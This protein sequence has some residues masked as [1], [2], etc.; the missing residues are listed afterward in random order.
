E[1]LLQLGEW[2]QLNGEGIYESKPW[3]KCQKDNVA[4]NIWYT[5][6]DAHTVYGFV[7]QWPEAGLVEF[8]CI[9]LA[10]VASVQ[11]LGSHSV[12]LT[13]KGLSGTVVHFPT[14]SP[15]L[16]AKY[17]FAFKFHLS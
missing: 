17:F 11:M 10:Q 16:K 14:W 7:H 15:L 9:D 3:A 6:K 13:E 12:I 8:G 1:R 5:E 2:L 4:N